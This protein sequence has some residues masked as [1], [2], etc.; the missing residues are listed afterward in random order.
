[1]VNVG[2]PPERA[3]RSRSAPSLIG[4]KVLAGSNIG[5]IA[6]TQEMLDFCAEHGIAAEIERSRADQVNDAYDRVVGSRRALPLR[7]R[8]RDHPGRLTGAS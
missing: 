4:D 8:H 6:Q 1:M 3:S 5:G 7:H 2:L